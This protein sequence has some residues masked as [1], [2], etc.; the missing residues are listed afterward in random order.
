ML[1]SRSQAARRKENHEDSPTPTDGCLLVVDDGIVDVATASAARCPPTRSSL[2]ERWD[3]VR[4]LAERAT[5]REDR[6]TVA[7]CRRRCPARARC[8][9][10]V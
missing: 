2:Y 7:R 8:S 5:G 10:S 6:S 3:E 9:P 1:R 4:A